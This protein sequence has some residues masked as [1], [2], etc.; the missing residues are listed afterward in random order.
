M[1]TPDSRGRHHTP[2]VRAAAERQALDLGAVDGTGVGGRVRLADVAAA[3]PTRLPSRGHLEDATTYYNLFGTDLPYQRVVNATPGA[4]RELV[5]MPSSLDPSRTVSIDPY[6]RN[7]LLADAEQTS[8]EA[9]RMALTEAPAPDVFLSGPLPPFLASGVDVRELLRLPWFVRHYAAAAPEA[10]TVLAMVEEFAH[11]PDL[12]DARFEHPGT[13]AYVARM[14]AWLIG[15]PLEVF[16]TAG[17][18]PAA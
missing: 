16:G 10:G 11:E 13:R 15:P 5:D 1:S 18:D 6:G 4:G 8:P 9:Y 2:A 14:R 17:A 3:A 12:A 7:P